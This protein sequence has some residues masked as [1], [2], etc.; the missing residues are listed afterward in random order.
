MATNPADLYL[1]GFVSRTRHVP[2]GSSETTSPSSS[3]TSLPQNK[4]VDQAIRTPGRQPS[5]QPTHLGVPGV[6]PARVLQETGPGYVAP[7]FEG[8]DKQMDEG[9]AERFHSPPKAYCRISY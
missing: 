9:E 3:S 8:K 5:P 6:P 7:E 2:N 1:S 4:L